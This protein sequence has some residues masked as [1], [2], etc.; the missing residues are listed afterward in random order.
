MH[1]HTVALFHANWFTGSENFVVDRIQFGSDFQP[2]RAGVE[3]CWFFRLRA[4]I[5]L[6]VLVA[7]GLCAYG[8]YMMRQRK[9]T[10][11]YIYI[12]GEIVVPLA[13]SLVFIGVG[14]LGGFAVILGILVPL[15]FII[16]YATQLKYLK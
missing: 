16:L 11:F 7:C 9:K 12:L 8:A 4:L 3:H 10:G 6:L 1:Q 5:L 2:I 15:V 13:A 14:S